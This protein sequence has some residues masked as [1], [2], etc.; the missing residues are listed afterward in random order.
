MTYPQNIYWTYGYNI[1][2]P[3]IATNANQ[4]A[5]TEEE[6]KKLESVESKKFD[7]TIS[8]EDILRSMCTHCRNGES[9]AYQL[10]DN[11]GRCACPICGS[12]WEPRTATKE[13]VKN[14]CDEL[15]DYMQTVKWAGGLASSTVREYFTIIPLLKK[16]P[17]LFEHALNNTNIMLRCMMN[18]IKSKHVV[19]DDKPTKVDSPKQ[20]GCAEEYGE[21]HHIPSTILNDK[22]IETLVNEYNH[23]K[24][25]VTYLNTKYYCYKRIINNLTDVRGEWLDNLHDML[26]HQYDIHITEDEMIDDLIKDGYIYKMPDRKHDE[27]MPSN[28]CILKGYM[29]TVICPSPKGD[30]VVNLNRLTP[31]G[32][33]HFVQYFQS[34]YPPKIE[35]C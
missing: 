15:I 26:V 27:Y 14:L 12:I 7:L 25:K 6:I 19:K 35:E 23:T 32:L 16:F 21:P 18:P 30:A 1:Y 22:D 4:N 33:D 31:N 28:S 17:D 2:P 8:E 11:T 13:N 3:H 34:K 5:L 10:N 20:I 29:I 9:V 24:D